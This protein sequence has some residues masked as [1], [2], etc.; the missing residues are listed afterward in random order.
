MIVIDAYNSNTTTEEL[1]LG[2]GGT[3]DPDDLKKYKIPAGE[4]HHIATGFL[5]NGL[6]LGAASDTTNKVVIHGYV[7]KAS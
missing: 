6:T 1:V 4:Y 5:R 3:T 2:W 7:L